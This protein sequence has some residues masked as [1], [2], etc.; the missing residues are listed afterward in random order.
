[1]TASTYVPTK[2]AASPLPN[3]PEPLAS[4]GAREGIPYPFF[5]RYFAALAAAGAGAGKLARGAREPRGEDADQLDGGV[6]VLADDLHE[7]LFRDLERLELGERLGGRRARHF[8]D[9]GDLA[10]EVVL[11]HGVDDDRPRGRGHRD[12]D[13]AVDDDVGRIAGVP[14]V[15]DHLPRIV[16]EALGGE[17]KQLLHR[18]LDLAEDRE[19]PDEFY[20]LLEAH[21]MPFVPIAFMRRGAA[22]RAARRSTS[23]R[24][25]Q[26]G[27]ASCRERAE[28]SGGAVS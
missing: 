21:R 22:S 27:R 12:L 4:R 7:E 10:E 24:R 23:G 11:A 8:A 19:L 16:V 1:M 6:R 9:D 28:N 17:A 26:I 2:R 3:M 20:F 18:R 13:R 15:E 14:G 5:R 25:M